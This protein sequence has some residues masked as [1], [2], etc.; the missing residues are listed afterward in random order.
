MQMDYESYKN[1]L[2]SRFNRDLKEILIDYYINQEH[3]PSV[4]A[5]QLGIPRQVVVHF[6]NLYNLNDLKFIQSE[7]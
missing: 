4:S 6:M 1:E 3:G 2:E 5:Q 7:E